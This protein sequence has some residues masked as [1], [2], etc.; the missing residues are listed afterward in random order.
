MKTASKLLGAAFALAAVV[1][2]ALPMSQPVEAATP[3]DLQVKITQVLNGEYPQVTVKNVGGT[4]SSAYVVQ[5]W[6]GYA[7]PSG[8]PLIH[9]EWAPAQG[10]GLPIEGMPALDAGASKS[11]A[12]HCPGSDG[13]KAIAGK[14]AIPASSGETNLDNNMEQVWLLQFSL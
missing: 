3:A 8:S 9:V 1:S 12:F 10:I 4:K 5:K 11:F 6:C 2:V 13:R 14:V 7:P